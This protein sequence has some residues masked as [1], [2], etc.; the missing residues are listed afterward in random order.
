MHRLKSKIFTLLEACGAI[1]AL[2]ALNKN[3]P[4][5]LMYHRIIE[6]E[7]ITGITPAELDQQLSYVAKH[8][9]V[10][11][12]NQLIADLHNNRVKPYTLA[13]TFD[14][15]HHDFFSNAW[16]ILKKYNLPATLYITT[17]FVS[18][19]CWLWPDALKFIL[20]NAKKTSI[21]T[22]IGNLDISKANHWPAW[23]TIGDHCLTLGIAERNNFLNDLAE[24]AEV[25][26]PS[27]PCDPFHGVTWEEVQQMVNE[28]LDIGSHTR[29]HPIL[30]GL[31][32]STIDDE[33]NGSIQDIERR[34]S[35]R[36][37]GLCYPNGRPQDIDETVIKFTKQAG[38][39]YA[40][41]GR[42]LPI[43]KNDLFKI[44]R[45]ATTNNISQFKW[46]LT[47][48]KQD[49]TISDYIA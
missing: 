3:K 32:E 6:K 9:N 7:F 31:P 35:K 44:G 4:L 28:G 14:D 26:L 18:G 19:D 21:T 34:I 42:N 23:H 22:A 27:A 40:V 37:T 10:V 48:R 49:S 2:Q 11:P 16:P 17:G 13:I 12:M 36:P 5:I 24:S 25:T 43:S 30:K 29:T 39:D 15:G 41:M 33:L 46:S 1:R 20:L 38:F 45:L 47:H 8:F